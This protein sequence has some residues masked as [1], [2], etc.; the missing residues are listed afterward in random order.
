[1][2]TCASISRRRAHVKGH[3]QP[4]LNRDEGDLCPSVIEEGY[5]QERLI[6]EEGNL[7]AREIERGYE[8][9]AWLESIPCVWLC[10]L[11]FEGPFPH[12]HENRTHNPANRAG[13]NLTHGKRSPSARFEHRRRRPL[14]RRSA[15][16]VTFSLA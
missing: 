9:K 12:Y 1:M 7:R 13:D 6:K 15:S 14:S 11:A 5:L 8:I 10:S 3:L 2:F 16:K 4:G